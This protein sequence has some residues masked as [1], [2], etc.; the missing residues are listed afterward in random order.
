MPRTLELEKEITP[1]ILAQM[2]Q[3]K[4]PSLSTQRVDVNGVVDS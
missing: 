1:M 2:G 4:S 3:V